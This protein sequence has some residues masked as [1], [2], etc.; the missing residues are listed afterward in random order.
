MTKATEPLAFTFC[1]SFA[2]AETKKAAWPVFAASVTRSVEYPNKQ[3]SIARES[4]VGGVREDE[5]RGRASNVKTRTILTLDYDDL[6]GITLADIDL[7]LEV[8]LA[9]CA[10]V[11][12]STY[13]HT[14]EAPRIRVF[15]P[16][17]R[18]VGKAEYAALVDRI[19]DDLG[20]GA[21]DPCSK[22]MAQIFFLASH[23]LG[24][25]PWSASGDGAFMDVGPIGICARE[26]DDNSGEG[27]DLAAIVAAQPLELSD[28]NVDALLDANPAEGLEYAD[29]LKIGMALAHQY[30]GSEAGYGRWLAWSAKSVKHD[31]SQMKTKWRS[32]KGT[33][34]PV[35][36]RSLIKASPGV[37]TA[38]RAEI[39]VDSV[40]AG[41]L[42]DEAD[43]V[44]DAESWALFKTRTHGLTDAALPP[45]RRGMLASV[46]HARWGK[47]AGLTL[48]EV[49]K[50]LKRPKAERMGETLPCPA[51]LD[52]WVFAEADL[53]FVN[54]GVDDYAIKDRGFRAKYD[55]MP[56]VV[57][58]ETDA[59]TFAL[60]LVQIP[61][62]VRGMYWPGMSALFDYA[63]KPCYNVYSKDGQAAADT[64][65][66]DADG[67]GV[68]DL[69]LAHVEHLIESER[70][71]D[72]L[73]DWMAYVYRNP[74]LRVR[75][76][77]LLWGVEGNGKTFFFHVLQRLMGRNAK[78][79][80]T[81]LIDSQF[82]NWAVGSCVTAIEEIRINGSNKYRILDKLK[83]MISNDTISHEPKG[84]SSHTVPNFASYMMMT[85]H[86]DAVPM[87]D[88][89]R[90]YCVIFT[91]QRTKEDLFALHG[92]VAAV[93][94]Y[95]AR[96]YGETERRVD[97]VGRFLLD[98]VLGA[99]FD[100][101]GRAPVTEGIAEMRAANV[102]D[103]EQALMDALEDHACDVISDEIV[104]TTWLNITT[105]AD[106]VQL[107]QGRALGRL[108]MGRGMAKAGRIK[109]GKTHHMVWHK[110]GHDKS[111]SDPLDR[112]RAWH[113]TRKV[114]K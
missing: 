13:R 18:A 96:L 110:P 81:D 57:A 99:E 25:T 75:W 95:F 27:M 50:A 98:R 5:Q 76:G 77:M 2:H 100:P 80:S 51:W 15:V 29:W 61:T 74:G 109:V 106:G 112:V 102:G 94:P 62:V 114:S 53:E 52:G 83:P 12:Y 21:P 105:L 24:V 65:E 67:Q 68:V 48:T 103:D 26:D 20:L 31:V 32:F 3:A 72:L 28:D 40:V 44:C 38:P 42:D 79:A 97:A 64:L 11:A 73:L 30:S 113:M 87:S 10:W 36:L 6:P 9:G 56:E 4:I 58:Q 1:K 33:A 34:S 59:A 19:A 93:G 88:N 49:K 104:D 39:A 92:G 60:N 22:V 17:S 7:Q 16:L 47:G 107:P 45:D 69:F 89:D 86:M 111:V 14:P 85:N 37:V 41:A 71:R 90:R 63:G 54:V 70:E 66:G 55:R 84:A 43:R 108:L 35:T 46:V 82:T 8:M 78:V 23:S 101:N 91:K